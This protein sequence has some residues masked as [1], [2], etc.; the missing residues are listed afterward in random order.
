MAE[1]TTAKKVRVVG[2]VSPTI[3]DTMRSLGNR[4][5]MSTGE[6]LREAIKLLD[7][8][9]ELEAE[10]G[11]LVLENSVHVQRH[12]L[13]MHQKSSGDGHRSPEPKLEKSQK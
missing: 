8:R 11:T 12:I 9:A 6:I 7:I 10:G 1:T 4:L 13:A 5:E 2:Y 3:A